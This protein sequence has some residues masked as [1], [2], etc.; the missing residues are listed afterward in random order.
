MKDLG[1]VLDS[2]LTMCDHISSVCRSA[3]LE[4]RRIGSTCSFLTVEAAA[5][6]AR[7]RILFRID[8]CNSVLAGM[9]SEQI[10]KNTKPRC[11]TYRP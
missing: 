2:G 6:L 11:P 9:T 4:L 10:A 5:E 8:Y 1:V 3:Y 7:S